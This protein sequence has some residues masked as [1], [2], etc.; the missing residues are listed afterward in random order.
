MDSESLARFKSKYHVND[1]PHPK[2]GTPCWLWTGA[3]T[4]YGYGYLTMPRRSGGRVRG[5]RK[6]GAHKLMYEHVNDP[7]PDGLEL[8][9]LCRV[10][11]CVNPE[12]LEAVTH[13]ENVRR[14]E[15]GH[16]N[17]VK[18]H[19]PQGHAYDE[20]GF[21]VIRSD[22]RGDYRRCKKCHADHEKDRRDGLGV[23]EVWCEYCGTTHTPSKT[24]YANNV[25]SNGEY[26]CRCRAAHLSAATKRVNP[27]ADEGKKQCTACHEVK[28]LKEFSVRKASWDGLESR[29]KACRKRKG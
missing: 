5:G 14:G 2:L 10:H 16:A 4:R 20:V 28:S 29:C 18:T 7:V 22:P 25:R 9:H 13:A 26:I 17:P 19:C 11:N 15:A 12:H 6:I 1:K 8:D 3:K 24:T 27:H 21:Y 23:V